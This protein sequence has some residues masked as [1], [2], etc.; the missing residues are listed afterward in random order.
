MLNFDL[1]QVI[2]DSKVKQPEV[3]LRAAFFMFELSSF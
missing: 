3:T 2:F 1:L